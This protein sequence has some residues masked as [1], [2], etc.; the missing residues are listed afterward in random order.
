MNI[1]QR[2]KLEGYVE[3]LN[4][5]M[6]FI[7]DMREEEEEKQSNLEEMG[8]EDDL[9]DSICDAIDTL[10]TAEDSLQEVIDSL[11]EIL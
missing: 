11:E 8:R 3:T 5:V 7:G 9:Y 6:G 10:E 2:K 4:K 1:R